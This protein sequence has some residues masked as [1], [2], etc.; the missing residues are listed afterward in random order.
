[1][2]HYSIIGDTSDVVTEG[3]CYCSSVYVFHVLSDVC[4]YD[5]FVCIDVC[6]AFVVVECSS[7]ILP[8]CWMLCK[9]VEWVY[10]YI[11]FKNVA[12]TFRAILRN[13]LSDNPIS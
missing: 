7:S 11:I 10:K 12:L 4:K 2:R 3:A 8:G 5:S 13:I 1:M 9:K 6:G